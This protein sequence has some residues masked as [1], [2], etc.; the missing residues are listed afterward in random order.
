MWDCSPVPEEVGA[1][2]GQ[3]FMKLANVAIRIIPQVPY[4]FKGHERGVGD[5]SV[6]LDFSWSRSHAVAVLEMSPIT[7]ARHPNQRGCRYHNMDG[8]MDE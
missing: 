8:W 1:V 3:R 6:K 7:A 2:G 4:G 5:S